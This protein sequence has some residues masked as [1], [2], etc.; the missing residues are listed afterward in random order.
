[1]SE[2]ANPP[3]G[4]V[5]MMQW[6]IFGVVLYNDRPANNL[7]D[8]NYDHDLYLHT[9]TIDLTIGPSREHALVRW[10][11]RPFRTRTYRAPAAVRIP[12]HTMH[13]VR[14][15]SATAGFWCIRKRF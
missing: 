10:L 13:Q 4:E 2:P 8:H 5:P 9:G 14:K 3:I 1:M 6:G 11:M 12:K 15:R 7:H